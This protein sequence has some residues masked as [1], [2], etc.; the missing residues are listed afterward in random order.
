MGRDAILMNCVTWVDAGRVFESAAGVPILVGRN[1]R[2]NEQLSLRIGRHPDVWFHAR[3][4]P[5]AHV[6]LRMSV[7]H[8][9][10]KDAQKGGKKPGS[11]KQSPAA[12]ED[13]MQMAADLV[14]PPKKWDRCSGT[15]QR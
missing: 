11:A 15:V 13:C 8:P 1:K 3:E 4:V 10:K 9:R 12:Q 5:G 6:V 7:V 14:S 2:E